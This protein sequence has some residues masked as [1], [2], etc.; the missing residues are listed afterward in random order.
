MA[1]LA[2]N[3]LI[4]KRKHIEKNPRVYSI[5]SFLVHA[6]VLV[7]IFFSASYSRY[8]TMQ[9][10]KVYR[11]SIATLPALNRGVKTTA[12]TRLKQAEK[13]N[14]VMKKV[15][16]KKKTQ[17]KVKKKK[18]AVGISTKNKSKKTV[19]HSKQITEKQIPNSGRSLSNTPSK[20][21]LKKGFSDSS[22]SIMDLDTTSF[23]Y[24]YYLAIVRDKIGNNWIRTYTGSG[25]V[26][27]YFKIMKNGEIRDAE[28]EVSSGNPGLDR[29]ALEAVLKSNPLPPLP[30][31]FREQYVGI[32]IW[33]NY[34]E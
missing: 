19:R 18:K 23:D 22:S 34:E 33:F 15:Y 28:V 32:H 25:K 3:I 12:T 8:K 29:L 6:F 21:G 24:A 31:G 26:K 4:E 10:P 2:I 16:R 5:F 13:V 14:K 20:G 30:E 7:L 27:I 17:P 11:V 9:K 1:K